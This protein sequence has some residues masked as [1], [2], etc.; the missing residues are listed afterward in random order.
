MTS[1]E[2]FVFVVFLLFAVDL[3]LHFKRLGEKLDKA[4]LLLDEIKRNTWDTKDF[5]EE[6]REEQKKNEE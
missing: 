2:W 5:L 3:N 6:M 4:I 1:S